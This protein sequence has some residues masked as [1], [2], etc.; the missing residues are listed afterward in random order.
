MSTNES[1]TDSSRAAGLARR[2]AAVALALAAVATAGAAGFWLGQG[3]SLEAL[4]PRQLAGAAVASGGDASAAPGAPSGSRATPETA[5]GRRILYYRNPMGL[6]DT[7]PTPK[8]DWMGMDYIAVH[9]GEEPEDGSIVKV[10]LDRVQRSGVRTGK[11]ERR[12]L[13]TPVRV[14]GTVKLDER[15]IK[16]VTLR[17]DGF[18]EELFVNATGQS[19]KAGQPL[20]RVYSAQLQQAQVDLI[21]ATREHKAR[22]GTGGDADPSI[23]NSMIE[24]PMQRL[25]NLDLP[26]ARIREVRA[27]GANPRTIDWPSPMSGIVLE[28]KVIDGQRAAMGSELYRIADLG[29]V[30]V[31]AEVPE[32]ELPQV[33]IGDRATAV[34]LALPGEEREGKV[35]FVYPDLKPETRTARVRIELPNPDLMLKTDMFAHVTIGA[36][37]SGAAV[38]AAPDSAVIDSG[39]RQ[40]VLVARGEGRFEPR[41]VKIGRRGEGMVEVIEGLAEGEEVVTSATFLIDAESNLKA[42]LQAFTSP[43]PAANGEQQP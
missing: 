15:R 43:P 17:F 25:R 6:P 3:R 7:S 4:W 19:V 23:P 13:A 24:G 34:F 27:T 21:V 36:G 10:S 28:K 2:G 40:V 30:W 41:A 33:R 29:T 42:A 26:E 32:Q 22:G 8:K 37:G 35:T 31:I 39:M 12:V 16:S 11:V 1:S 9:E 5:G 38:I 14:P 18:I 20:F